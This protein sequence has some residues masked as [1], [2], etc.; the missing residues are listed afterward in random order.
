V[1][2]AEPSALLAP[3]RFAWRAGH[4]AWSL[5][6]ELAAEM[7]AN[8]AD[9]IT[10]ILAT[11]AMASALLGSPLDAVL[12]GSVVLTNAALSAQQQL[13]AQRI[14]TR[15]LAVQ[16]PP[17]P[18]GPATSSRSTQGRSSQPTPG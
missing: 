3:A 16:D 11:G 10:P 9:P 4:S 12:V 1:P 15:L 2:A 6:T 5:T 14:L 13:H 17:Q 7:R 18:C 8:L